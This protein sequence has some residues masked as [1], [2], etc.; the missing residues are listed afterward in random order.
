MTTNRCS[1]HP[2]YMADNCPRC[3]TAPVIPVSREA[4]L[5]LAIRE[6]TVCHIRETEDYPFPSDEWSLCWDHAAMMD[7]LR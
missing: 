1:L 5:A 4:L 7:N 6:C 2:A 3:G